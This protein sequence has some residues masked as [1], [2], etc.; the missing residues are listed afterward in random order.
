MLQPAGH[1]VCLIASIPY[2]NQKKAPTP[3][4]IAEEASGFPVEGLYMEPD[5]RN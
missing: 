2:T 1:D 4:A 3:D 5:N